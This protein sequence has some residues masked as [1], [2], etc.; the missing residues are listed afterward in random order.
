MDDRGATS[1]EI[2]SNGCA[3]GWCSFNQTKRRKK[4]PYHIITDNVIWRFFTSF[5]L[6]KGTPT[7]GA[8]VGSNLIACGAPIIHNLSF[9]CS[10][11]CML[12]FSRCSRT[13]CDTA[14]RDRK[15][16]KVS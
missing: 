9:V 10:L 4:A 5:G 12:D 1:D 11:L 16:N 8:T 3:I 13:S 14:Y 2:R 15:R 6:V 7:D